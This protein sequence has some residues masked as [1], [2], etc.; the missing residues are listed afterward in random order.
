MQ[1]IYGFLLN[2]IIGFVVFKFYILI[3]DKNV[4][5][6]SFYITPF[7]HGTYRFLTTGMIVEPLR[8]ILSFAFFGIIL[9]IFEKKV[10]WIV[11]LIS[12]LTAQILWIFATLMAFI[13]IV[14]LNTENEFLFLIVGLAWSIGIFT[15]VLMLDKHKKI[16]LSSYSILLESPLVRKIIFSISILVIMLYSFLRI[17]AD[18]YIDDVT[19][20]LILW[21]MSII[22]TL[23]IVALVIFVVRHLIAERKKQLLLEQENA[24]LI[25]ERLVIE[26]Q[27]AE[28]ETA[29]EE[30]Q[31]DFAEMTSNHHA[32]KY[33]IPVFIKMQNELIAEMNNFTEYSHDEKLKRI[34]DYTT[35]VRVLSFEINDEFDTDHIKN[36]IAGLNIPK[37]WLQ[38]TM[39]LESLM[40]VAQ[41][42]G[43]YLSVYNHATD[44]S[45][46]DISN[47]VL[48][49]LLSNIVDNAIKETCK[50]P[51]S[52]RGGI[53]IVFKNED[54]YF[55]F[56]V[57][58]HAP[59]FKIS[60]LEKLGQRKNSTNGTGDGYAEVLCDLDDIN[61][62][63]IIREWKKENNG[64]GK[65]ISVIFDGFNMRLI[66]SH[67]RYEK[68]MLE[69]KDTNFE[70]VDI[71]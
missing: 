16:T 63:F 14:L 11:L 31:Q 57:T 55:M 8:M 1:Q 9:M 37:R 27:M 62:S 10:S 69:L 23:T 17:S 67:Y 35:Q 70:V 71:Y 32:Y 36:E 15:G 12:F 18:F 48:I 59:E 61:A 64:Y 47:V 29:Q 49:R 50:L 65:A 54:D 51:H 68:L 45:N 56:E 42:K 66:D 2:L 60:I 21:G 24:R 26:Q 53:R 38:L 25:K 52:E 4:K 5:K 19:L 40:K 34:K 30:L 41:D 22:L 28:L 7:L 39:L 20:S 6:I 43:I 46:L 44:W 58:D 13:T 3:Q 33:A